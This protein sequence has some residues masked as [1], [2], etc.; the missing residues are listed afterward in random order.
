M[1]IPSSTG[2]YF[3]VDSVNGRATSRGASPDDAINSIV[4]ALLL[5]TAAKNDVI[6]CVPGHVETITAAAGVSISTS[7][8]AIVGL[9]QGRLRPT[10]NYTTSA[11]ASFD[12]TAANV[13]IHNLVFTPTGVASI[14]SAINVSGANFTMSS[15]EVDFANAT[16]QAL[17]VLTSTA[18]ATRM[19]IRDNWFHGTNNAGT[20]VCLKIVGGDAHQIGFN[21]CS[22]AFTTTLGFIQNVTTACTNAIVRGNII[23]NQTAASTTAMTFAAT[24]T[25]QIS[26]N[27]MQILAGTAPI[28]GAAMSWSGANYYSAVI[29]TA[30]T[31]I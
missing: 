6:V 19:T 12:V 22:G 26:E 20:T 16:N 14:T 23:F 21:H 7:G 3:F 30:S 28:V 5:T 1:G 25:G 29:A 2:T 15:C 18:A 4:N 31:L 24:S 27:K 17:I 13:T 10:I 9:G 11:A 8:V